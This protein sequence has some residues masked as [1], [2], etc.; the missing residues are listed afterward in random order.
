VLVKRRDAY[1]SQIS[2]LRKGLASIELVRHGGGTSDLVNR[3][4]STLVVSLGS[5]YRLRILQ[6]PDAH[7]MVGDDETTYVV[8]GRD[9]TISLPREIFTNQSCTQSSPRPPEQR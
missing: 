5:R 9:E 1:C 7:P 2:K 4:G 8:Y 3:A 6:H